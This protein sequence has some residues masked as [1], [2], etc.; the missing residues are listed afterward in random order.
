M[1]H[2]GGT[3]EF[4]CPV[5]IGY[6]LAS[7]VRR[8]LQNPGKI[9]GPHIEP[10]MLVADIGCAMGFFSLDMARMVDPG[11]RVVCVDLQAGMIR[12]LEKRARKAGLLDLIDT[13]VCTSDD[14]GL[15]DLNGQLDFALAFDVIH[16]ASEPAPFLSQ[17]YAAVRPGGRFLLVEP[18]GHVDVEY[19]QETLDSAFDAGF[20]AV[21]DLKILQSRAVL[22]ER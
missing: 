13:R 14:L 20:K 16:E 15:G 21:E 5:W 6:L 11:G 22:L 17:V 12:A 4:V 19:Y 10:G 7:P 8:I 2:N 9:L 3:G 18:K 1:A